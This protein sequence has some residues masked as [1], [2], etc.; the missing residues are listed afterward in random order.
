MTR[1]L[2]E[3]AKAASGNAQLRLGL[4]LKLRMRVGEDWRG[5]GLP[6]RHSVY[7]IRKESTMK[8]NTRSH[9]ES[10]C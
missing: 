4:W 10:P 9:S 3:K 8:L 5:D 7:P 2:S 6:L 1:R